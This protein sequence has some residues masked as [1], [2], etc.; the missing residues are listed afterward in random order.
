M[1]SGKRK[2]RYEIQVTNYSTGEEKTVYN[3]YN[4]QKAME[5]YSKY[6]TEEFEVEL[7]INGDLMFVVDMPI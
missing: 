7:Y 1:P 5:I 6:Q 3:G 2:E 4:K